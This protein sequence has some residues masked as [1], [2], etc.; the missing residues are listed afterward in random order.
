[1][2]NEKLLTMLETAIMATLAYALSFIKFGGFWAQGGSISLV[3]IPI[4]LLSFRRGV[5]AGLTAGLIVGLLKL[6]LGGSIVHPVQVL[7]D[8]PLPY[9]VIGLSG[10][11]AASGAAGKA[12]TMT[13]AV[14]GIT[15]AASLRF[16]CHFS[17]GIIWFGS[18]APEGMHAAWYS[19]LYNVSYLV[20]EILINS[21]IIWILLSS[22]ASLLTPHSFSR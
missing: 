10:L 7:L 19:F 12:A 14:L 8:Y 4:V 16:L 9:A 6:M 1:M 17:S 18:F 20:P 3:M 22:R 11:F 15:L 21:T 5:K 13:R 2:R